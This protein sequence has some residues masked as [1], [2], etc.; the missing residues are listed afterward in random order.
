MNGRQ[1]FEPYEFLE[2]LRRDD[3]SPPVVLF[4]MVKLPEGDDD[5]LFFAHGYAC[6]NWIRI[7]RNSIERIDL[8]NFVPCD[9]HKHP[10]V[11]VVL[12]Q[13]ETDEGRLFASLAQRTPS[14]MPGR[15]L[16]PARGPRF[17][18]SRRSTG[19]RRVFADPNAGIG[20]DP[21]FP[22]CNSIPQY[23]IDPD[24]VV[25]CL[26]WCWESEHHASYTPTA[27]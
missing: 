7:P 4:G 6:E 25:Y 12:K 11:F 2:R 13:P 9:D 20:P 10:L 27:C 14:S 22:W 3:I 18:G 15:E 8:V 1:S 26:D 17:F 19:P 16:R 21:E 5:Y 23:E 24:G